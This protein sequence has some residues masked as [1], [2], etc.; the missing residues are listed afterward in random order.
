MGLATD[1]DYPHQGY[2]D[3]VDNQINPTSGTIRGRAVFDNTDGDFIPGLFARIKLVGSASYEGILVDDKA[4]ATDLNNKFVMVVNSDNV[5]EYRAVELGEKLNGLRIVKSGLSE[6]DQIVVNGLQRVRP[7]ASVTPIEVDMASPATIASLKQTQMLI[8][9][10]QQN[11]QL[12]INNTIN[13]VV[14][15]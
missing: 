1:K 15:G 14:G 4:I 11:T 8:D 12:A 9:E 7:G 3:F 10:N 5:V 13:T 6:D 2:I